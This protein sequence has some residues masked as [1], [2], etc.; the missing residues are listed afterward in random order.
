MIDSELELAA[1]LALDSHSK[2]ANE[3]ELWERGQLRFLLHDAQCVI[4]DAFHSK[5]WRDTVILAA[6][7][8]G[9]STLGLILCLEYCI[10]HPYKI[11]RFIPPEVK[12][13]WQIVMPTWAKLQQRA[14]RGLIEYKK[15]EQAF[16]VGQDSWIFLGGFDSQA[17]AQRGGEASFIVCD[18]GGSTNPHDYNY[19]LRSVLKPQ[20]LDTKG[21]MLHLG[22]VP[23]D[24]SH[25]FLVDTVDSAEIDGRLFTFTIADNPRL[26]DEQRQ[27]AIEDCGG[28]DTED[29]RRE[30]L[31]ERVRS[32]GLM[33]IN[34]IDKLTFGHWPFPK[35]A[36]LTIVGDWGGVQDKTVFV[37]GCYDF[38]REQYFIY[39]ERHYP[40]HTGLDEIAQGIKE[41]EA[42]KENLLPNYHPDRPDRP[43]LSRHGHKDQEVPIWCDCPGQVKIDLANRHGII[44]RLPV[45]DEFSAGIKLI[46][47]AITF[48]RLQIH[49]LCK[50]VIK[51]LQEAKFN[52]RRTDYERS[53]LLGH[54][55]AVAAVIYFLRMASCENPNPQPK[56]NTETH[57]YNNTRDNEKQAYTQIANRMLAWRK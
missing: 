9:K 7:R 47:Y 3:Q 28:E 14:P 13:A 1:L 51:S 43:E 49:A 2:V 4:Y 46:N 24:L 53:E 8:F 55:D 40:P 45:K 31:C 23:P 33:V 22:T 57:F 52:E 21:R 39:A 20:L 32:R 29:Y 50:F 16:R 10:R 44:V 27:Q 38:Q 25:P 42:L 56:R 18:E 34:D 12:Q 37:L 6:R 15:A 35:Y 36:W 41:L 48:Q 5:N 30:Y 19:I 26:D 11:A 54:C 17:D